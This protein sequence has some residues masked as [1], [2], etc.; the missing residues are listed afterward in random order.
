[1]LNLRKGGQGQRQKMWR[2]FT[3]VFKYMTLKLHIKEGQHAFF[4][5][6]RGES[7]DLPGGRYKKVHFGFTFSSSKSC[8]KWNDL[9]KKVMNFPPLEECELILV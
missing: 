5:V 3:E 9:S 4:M 7:L 2:G 8:P 1:M 6:P